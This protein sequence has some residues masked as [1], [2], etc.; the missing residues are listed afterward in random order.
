MTFLQGTSNQGKLVMLKYV[1][2][3]VCSIIMIMYRLSYTA[4]VLY[5]LPARNGRRYAYYYYSNLLP[6]WSEVATLLYLQG[7]HY[8]NVDDAILQ[9]LLLLQMYHEME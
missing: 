9:P 6:K 4:I 7:L 1:A 3:E 8:R 5:G 2:C